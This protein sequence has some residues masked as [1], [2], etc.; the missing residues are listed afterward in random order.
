MKNSYDEKAEA[1]LN[2]EK[3]RQFLMLW[4][5]I[6][7]IVLV[8]VIGILAAFI[9]PAPAT[10]RPPSN[11]GNPR[12]AG[13]LNQIMLALH[14]YHD[15]YGSFPPAYTTDASGKALHSWR[16]LILPFLAQSSLYS[17]IRLDEPWDSEYNR[18][19]QRWMPEVYGCPLSPES[20]SGLTAFQWII[21][22]D[23]ISD[24]PT[25]RTMADLVR[26]TSNTIVVVEVI[27]STNWME[28]VDISYS[29]LA[30]GINHSKTEGVGSRHT[31]GTATVEVGMADGA[32]RRVS[33][34]DFLIE[35]SLIRIPLPAENPPEPNEAGE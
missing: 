6:G 14:N 34:K 25:A 30:K 21:G 2:S 32:V 13:H 19:F 3:N 28:P 15:T 35:H 23:T 9:G 31:A 20:L 26:G 4:L 29:D 22:P 8:V 24:G 17:D 7:L 5:G 18:Q 16:V 33:D 12:C 27:P 11:S 10:M 1:V